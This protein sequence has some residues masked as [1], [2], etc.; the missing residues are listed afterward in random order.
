MQRFQDRFEQIPDLRSR[1]GRGGQTLAGLRHLRTLP[2]LV[3]KGQPSVRL[4]SIVRSAFPWWAHRSGSVLPQRP[5]NVLGAGQ[6]GCHKLHWQVPASEVHAKCG[7]VRVRFG[8]TWS[9]VYIL[10]EIWLCFFSG[11][12]AEGVFVVTVTGMVGAFLIPSDNQQSLN[13][14]GANPTGVTQLQSTVV[15]PSTT[16]SLG[17]SRNFID[18]ADISHD[19]GNEEDD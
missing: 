3:A 4:A 11:V 18:T 8:N 5:E 9:L 19:K 13:V 2:D 7:A 1:M 16:T 12:P 17:P 6:E 14:N 10:S 15:L